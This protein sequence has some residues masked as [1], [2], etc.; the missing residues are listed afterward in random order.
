[1]SAPR[2][3]MHPCGAEEHRLRAEPF[4]LMQDCGLDRIIFHDSADQATISDWRRVTAPGI[5]WLVRV[6]DNDAVVIDANGNRPALAAV[7][8]L[9]SWIGRSAMVHFAVFR[10]WREEAV[11]IGRSFLHWAFGTGCIDSLYGVTPKTYRHALEF[12]QRLGFHAETALPG[13]CHLARQERHVPGIISICTPETL[14]AACH[15]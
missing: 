10:P 9:N 11:H 7:A 14:E 8:W 15:E 5:A 1:M 13:A 4:W 6:H 3:T 2:F 12:V